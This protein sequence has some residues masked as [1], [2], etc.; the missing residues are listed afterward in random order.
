M[1]VRKDGIHASE[2]VTNWLTVLA[3]LFGLVSPFVAYAATRAVTDHRVGVIEQRLEKQDARLE[4]H[5]GHLDTINTK[6]TDIR[7]DVAT[8]LALLQ[9]GK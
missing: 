4:K 7:E 6:L 3:L 8:A 2:K 1:M 9:R 5:E